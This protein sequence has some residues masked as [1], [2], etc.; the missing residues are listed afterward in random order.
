M[1]KDSSQPSITRSISTGG[2]YIQFA[3][4]DIAKGIISLDIN[5]QSMGS[6]KARTNSAARI[7]NDITFLPITLSLPRKGSPP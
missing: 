1:K 7:I 2:K 5:P 3:M 4:N 6:K